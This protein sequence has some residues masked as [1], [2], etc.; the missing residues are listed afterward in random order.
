MKFIDA[1]IFLELMLDDEKAIDCKMFFDKLKNGEVEAST[2]DF[3]IYTCLLQIQYKFKS[4]KYLKN[5]ILFINEMKGL[6]IFRPSL[7]DIYKSINIS[8]KYK[9]DFDDSL[10]VSLM[11]N[12]NIKELISF[13]KHFDKVN[14]IKRETP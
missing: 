5:F 14:L 1:N 10:V 6:R 12:N 7:N 4:L 9:L 13:D 8:E 3:I 2:S 11:I